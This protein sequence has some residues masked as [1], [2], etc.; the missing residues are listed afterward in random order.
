[1]T[2]MLHRIRHTCNYTWLDLIGFCCNVGDERLHSYCYHDITFPQ[3]I[4]LFAV[5][6]R[7]LAL[8]EVSHGRLTRK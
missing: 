4:T 6:Q 5:N 7:E 8:S 3:D 1:M 2:E